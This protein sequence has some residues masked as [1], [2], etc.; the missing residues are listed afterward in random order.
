LLGN[1]AKW[2]ALAA[3]AAV[4]SILALSTEISTALLRTI[5]RLAMDAFGSSNSVSGHDRTLNSIPAYVILKRID[6]PAHDRI[7]RELSG[8]YAEEASEDQ[9]LSGARNVLFKTL[10]PYLTRAS[11][12]AVLENIDIVISYM[13]GLKDTDAESCVSLVDEPKGAK[14]AAQLTKQFP[15]LMKRELALHA[16]ILK[17]DGQG[18]PNAATEQQAGPYLVKVFNTIAARPGTKLSLLA[19]NKLAPAEYQDYCELTLALFREVRLL[20]KHE[21]VQ[22]LRYLYSLGN[23]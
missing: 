18:S 15:E 7:R 5:T 23:R 21:A 8:R 4:L 11:D 6:P 22:V 10:Q 14:L 17:S 2:A 1:R 20:P 12:A 19:R 3:I 13:D 16:E 9:I